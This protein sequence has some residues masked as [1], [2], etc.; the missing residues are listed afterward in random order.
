MRKAHANKAHMG[1][2]SQDGRVR[3]YSCSGAYLG[4]YKVMYRGL[5]PCIIKYGNTYP[6][7]Q[8]MHR[9]SGNRRVLRWE[10][11]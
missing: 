8:V 5:K 10:L 11:V 6:V 9:L 2:Y 7:Q 3:V 4:R 1:S